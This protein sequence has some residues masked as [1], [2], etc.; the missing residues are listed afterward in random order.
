RRGLAA[1]RRPVRRALDEGVLEFN[2]EVI[3]AR[4][5]RPERDPGLILRVAAASATTGLP[6]A[7]STLSRLAAS[8]PELRTPWPRQ[9]LKDLL[10][11][12]AAGPAA[13]STIEALDRT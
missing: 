6:M 1:L 10:V 7:G 9:A 4:G 3:L 11:T 2:G 13:V 12:L 5:A 8:A